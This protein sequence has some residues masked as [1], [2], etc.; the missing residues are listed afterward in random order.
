MY[1]FNAKKPSKTRRLKTPRKRQESKRTIRKTYWS[2]TYS[3]ISCNEHCKMAH[4]SF[5]VCVLTL[6]F[7]R[8]LSNWPVLTPWTWIS[9][10]CDTPLFFIVSHNLSY[11][12]IKYRIR[13]Q[14]I[15]CFL[16]LQPLMST[17]KI[18][19]HNTCNLTIVHNRAIYG[20][21][22]HFAK[23]PHLHFIT[24]SSKILPYLICNCDFFFNFNKEISKNDTKTDHIVQTWAIIIYWLWK[25][26]V[27]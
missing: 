11:I 14:K 24:Q 12:I 26:K 16:G 15:A 2:D 18:V 23:R 27:V 1:A 9:W 25:C 13:P 4:N 6:S 8:N 17:T 3:A 10:Y 21:A 22:L 7:L 19:Y 5:N 20:N